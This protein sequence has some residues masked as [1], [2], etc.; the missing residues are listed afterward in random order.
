MHLW[1]FCLMYYTWS[2]KV[3]YLLIE[4]DPMPHSV[5]SSLRRKLLFLGAFTKPIFIHLSLQIIS[6]F[7]THKYIKC[8]F[9][10]YIYLFLHQHIV[11][12]I[13]P[14]KNIYCYDMVCGF[15]PTSM[16]YILSTI[17]HC[18]YVYPQCGDPQ[19]YL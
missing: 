10:C 18:G 5:H 9:V 4:Y 7:L 3:I 13:Q 17:Y 16:L 15:L 1:V 2:T 6:V 19:R 12:G 11:C 8:S 14:T